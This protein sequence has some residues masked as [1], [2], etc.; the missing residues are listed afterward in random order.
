MACEGWAVSLLTKPGVRIGIDTWVQPSASY[1]PPPADILLAVPMSSRMALA[2]GVVIAERY[3]L[4]ERIGGG[5][6]GDVYRAEHT[7]AGRVVALK[8]LR[9]D[10]ARD[11][12]HTQRFFQ[13]AQAVNRIRHPNIVDVLDAG[14]SEK[15]PYVVMECLDGVSVGAALSCAKRLT[16]GAAI[17]IMLPVLE[18]L[19]AAHWRGIVHR[20]L[21][22]E[23]LFIAD[24]G[25]SLRVKILDFGIAK[26][27]DH[28]GGGAEPRT[29]T[30]L[31]YGTPDYL[32][33][34]QATGDRVVDGRSDV[35]AAAIVLFE[36]LSGRRPFSASTMLATAYKIA[37]E[38]APRLADLGVTVDGRVQAA[39]ERAL[40]KVRDDRLASA[41]AFADLLAPA[42]P[43]ESE[44]QRELR[45]LLDATIAGQPTE[46]APR[47][48]RARD[49]GL[50]PAPAPGVAGPPDASSAPTPAAPPSLEPTPTLAVAPGSPVPRAPSVPD[51]AEVTGHARASDA[52]SGPARRPLPRWLIDEK[53]A[54]A[55]E[56]SVTSP[57]QHPTPSRAPG[58]PISTGRTPS[59]PR[60]PVGERRDFPAFAT[61]SGGRAVWT[62]RPLPAQA[63]ERCH[64][65]GHF[66]R[67][68]AQWVERAH[69]ADGLAEV[70]SMLPAAQADIFRRD[71]FNALVWYPLED[72]DRFVEAAT[73]SVLG[74]DASAWRALAQESFDRTLG[75]VM[76]SASHGGDLERGLK[77]S[78]G[79]WPR[80]FDF[81]AVR[82]SDA[83]L[84]GRL[85]RVEVTVSD[86][87]GASAA[88]RHAQIGTMA[89]LAR[90]MGAR[91]VGT[92][93]VSGEESFARELTY[94]IAW[95]SR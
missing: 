52:G 54:P 61:P 26:V 83:L 66:A 76:R 62:A 6:M 42:A 63:R 87:G 58:A 40:V 88:L 33:P 41:A 10:F 23:N 71:G 80:I 14:F 57:P 4:V 70:L 78:S 27:T 79:A 12:S 34:E 44:R 2:P 19:E 20:D 77:R 9:E 85:A 86:F 18:A 16:Q 73:A 46:V 92:R 35:F 39:L 28:E 65:R 56:A 49:V 69:G 3:R 72:A 21:K 11:E 60:T 24:A 37:H 67:A 50:A 31:I 81:G 43:D 1:C 38:P 91:D 48:A 30:G 95:S 45:A 36:L 17:A 51:R 13:E 5:G 68:V 55:A 90:S 22:P 32:S 25:Q 53:D 29:R 94:E 8:L 75:S 84:T 93:V 47:L 15:G 64:V 74:G 82:V 7:L 89:G 59:R